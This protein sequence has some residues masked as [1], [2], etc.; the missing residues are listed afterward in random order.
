[1]FDF[2]GHHGMISTIFMMSKL[3]LLASG[4][5]DGRLILWD[6]VGQSV[7]MRY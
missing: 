4:G 3:Q 6:T 1:M 2:K 7:K 5:F